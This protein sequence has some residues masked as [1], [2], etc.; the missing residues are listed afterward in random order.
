LADAIASGPPLLFPALKE[1][2]RVTEAMCVQDAF[3]FLSS[4]ALSSVVRLNE[5]ED[6]REGARAFAEKREPVWQGR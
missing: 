3:K 1:T 2:I 4:G 5:S 6:M